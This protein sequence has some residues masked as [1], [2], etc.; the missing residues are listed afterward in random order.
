MLFFIHDNPLSNG[1]MGLIPGNLVEDYELVIVLALLVIVLVLFAW[2]RW[3]Y[4]IVAL[5]ALL[6]L[7]VLGI[8]NADEAFMGFAHPAVITVAAV[9]VV[10][11]GLIQSGLIDVVIKTISKAGENFVFQLTI[12]TV[13]V[14][15]LSAFMN[16][17]GAMALMLPIAVRI[18]RK[19]ERSPS[20]Y[21]MPIAFGSLLGG[22]ITL[23]GTPPNIIIA[24]ARAENSGNPFSMFDFAPVGIP[25]AFFGILFIVMLGWKLIPQRKDVEAGQL[26]ANIK[27]YI[28]ELSVPK[29]SD[30]VGKR[31]M[32]ISRLSDS[33]VVIMALVRGK[34]VYRAPSAYKLIRPNDTLVVKGCTENI[35]TLIDD[36]GLELHEERE[37]DEDIT[38]SE[39]IELA[40]VV[41][42]QNS[43]MVGRTVKGLRLH[44]RYGLNLLAIS[45]Q[46]R[47]IIGRLDST[48]LK[49]GDLLLIQG[50]RET[51]SSSS[52]LLGL[53]PLASGELSL[54]RP[55]RI[56]FA[57]VLFASGIL[58]AA[59]GYLPIAVSIMVVAVLMVVTGL[60]PVKDLYTSIDWP[61]IIL[62]G[63]MIPVG[64]AFDQV[65]GTTLIANLILDSGPMMTPYLAVAVIMIVSMLLSDI[66]N[67][68]AVAVLMAPL[69]I[70]IASKMS[71]S[72]D[73]MLMAV[74][75][76]AS[77]AFLTPIGHQSNALVM[78][79]GGYRFTDYWPMG[80]PL[81][82]VIIIVALPSIFLIWP[83]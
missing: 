23:I 6:T 2:N 66:I 73:P 5:M 83:F 64:A 18:A 43:L 34:Q 30:I 77:C 75:I 81:Q 41:I 10:T 49:E 42:S 61:I 27:D 59:F 58:A 38:S 57:L 16:N 13:T 19:S 9:L 39:E 24:M 20:I 63:A 67:N 4:D 28:T 76:G 11:R 82:I 56:Y 40:E 3:R 54:G 79:P 26:I 78:G 74:A 55:K 25:I 71:V 8:V 29:D 12:L 70:E 80:L 44:D 14:A 21:L 69:A 52:S 47:D 15:V 33:E 7:T 36:L 35:K 46:G 32:E 17:I 31:V 37:F 65:G 22:L 53:I 1:V 60:V 48:T 50:P 68:A 62:L 45:R 51:I 72:A